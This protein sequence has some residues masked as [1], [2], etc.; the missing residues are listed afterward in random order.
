MSYVAFQSGGHNEHDTLSR[1]IQNSRQSESCYCSISNRTIR[2]E[3]VFYDGKGA[4]G[5]QAH[6]VEWGSS[7]G[8]TGLAEEREWVELTLFDLLRRAINQDVE[9]PDHAGDGDDVESDRAHDLSPLA[10]CHLKL[11]P[12]QRQKRKREIKENIML[13]YL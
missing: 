9:R 5:K 2:V 11:L 7:G 10:G 1:L 13:F 3:G 8:R 6:G 4:V 12:L